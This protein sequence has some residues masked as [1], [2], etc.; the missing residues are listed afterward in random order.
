M[1]T[2]T[3][4]AC[5]LGDAGLAARRQ[6]IAAGLLPLVTARVDLADGVALHF[7]GSA[8]VF[9]DVSGFV[10]IERECCPFLSF[11]II[12][13]QDGGEIVLRIRGP[14]GAQTFLRELVAA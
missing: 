9:T 12:A 10:A 13:R 8:G 1:M 7:P 5:R 6:Q 11:E 3:A 2:E 4:F 14:E